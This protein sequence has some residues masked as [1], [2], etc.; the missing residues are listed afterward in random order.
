MFTEELK[1]VLQIFNEIS[2]AFIPVN[3]NFLQSVTAKSSRDGIYAAV[4]VGT[5]ESV[6]FMTQRR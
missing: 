5:L 4:D 2:S 1:S 6:M 3:Y